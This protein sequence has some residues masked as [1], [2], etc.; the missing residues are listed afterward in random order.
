MT[1][2]QMAD[3]P[4]AYVLLKKCSSGI[5]GVTVKQRK[6]MAEAIQLLGDMMDD[7]R[8]GATI[9]GGR[10]CHFTQPMIDHMHTLGYEIT[11]D[12]DGTGTEWYINIRRDLLNDEEPDSAPTPKRTRR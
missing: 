9:G 8:V 3:L 2:I 12:N 10:D 4:P 1:G 11:S 5:P 6:L 7:P